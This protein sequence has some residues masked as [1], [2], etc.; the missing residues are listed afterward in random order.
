MKKSFIQ[1]L[2]L[3]TG[4]SNFYAQ[5]N[6]DVQS[7][8]EVL[9]ISL[10]EKFNIPLRKLPLELIR[11]YCEGNIKAY[12]PLDTTKECSYHEFI[13]HFQTGV[14]QPENNSGA[15]EFASVSCPESFCS[16]NDESML[17]NFLVKFELLQYKYFDRE[18][19]TEKYDVKYIRLK[20]N[21]KLRGNNYLLEGPVFK[22]RDIVKLSDSFPEKYKISNAK[23]TAENFSIRKIIE[24]RM[25]MGTI[26]NTENKNKIFEKKK[27]NLE[28][29][30]YHY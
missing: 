20:F 10:K 4:I 27:E 16:N 1:V 22:Y 21:N 3:F 28:Q 17:E 23:N 25:F 9:S 2:L 13:A 19:S 7:N 29:D 8:F 15:T 18:K 12:Y 30:R 5:K 14:C 24:S 11:A 26:E 6:K